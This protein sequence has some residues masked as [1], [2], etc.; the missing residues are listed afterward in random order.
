MKKCLIIILCCVF[1]LSACKETQYTE[2][3][4]VT[5]PLPTEA[6]PTEPAS[7]ETTIAD[8]EPIADTELYAVSVPLVTETYHADDGTVL[9]SYAAQHMQLIIPDENTADRVVLDFLNRVDT[10]AQNAQN[11]LSAA[12]TDYDPN[13]IWY[14]YYYQIIYNPTRIDKGVLSL[15]GSQ[16]SYSGTHGVLSSVAVNY[17]LTTGDHLTLGSI[18]HMD[19]QKEDFIPLIIDKLNLVA[20][21]YYLYDDFESGVNLRLSGD[22]NLYEDFYFTQT[23][24][25]FFFSPYEIAPYASGVINV[26]IPY[27]ELTGLIYDGY[28]PSEREQVTGSMHSGDFMQTD[29]EQFDNMAD[30][31]L[32]TGEAIMVVYP[33]GTV[34]DIRIRM[35]GDGINLPEYT[36]FA[37]MKMSGRNAVILSLRQEDI[38]QTT[39]SY[40][41]NGQTKVFHLS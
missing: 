22:E 16:S 33:E 12:Q 7:T 8:M 13:E 36:V 9:Y 38:A 5:T 41:S 2:I 40:T 3:P 35:A 10:F 19:A 23:G 29:M 37:A 4:L 21:E 28:F 11:V 32:V 27:S 15:V 39:V 14:P 26:E 20:D 30:V 24:L 34:E 25:C 31:T 18:M 6:K 17:D 1:L